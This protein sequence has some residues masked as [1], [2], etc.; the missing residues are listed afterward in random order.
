VTFVADAS[1]ALAWCFDDE[2]SDDADAALARL[3]HDDAIVPAIWPLEVA[4]G[5]VSAERRERLDRAD[6]PRLRTLLT[7]LPVRVEPTELAAALGEVTEVARDFELSA[8]DATYLS[9]AMRLGLPM[10]TVDQRLRAA[11]RRAR[12]VLI[13]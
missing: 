8:Y 6:L 1:V 9:L 11:A 5:L 12:V 3:E 13:P 7:S 2:T 4:N 10:A